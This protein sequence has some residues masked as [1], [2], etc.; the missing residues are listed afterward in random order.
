MVRPRQHKTKFSRFSELSVEVQIIILDY[1]LN[2]ICRTDRPPTNGPRRKKDLPK[3]LAPF[4]CVSRI[5]QDYFESKTFHN[6][7]LGPADIP[8]FCSMTLSERRRRFVKHV[9][10]I[11][12]LKC[13]FNLNT[14]KMN[15]LDRGMNNL[16]FTMAIKKLL[17][18][19]STWKVTDNQNISLEIGL[20]VPHKTKDW[21]ADKRREEIYSE[22]LGVISPWFV[23]YPEFFWHGHRDHWNGYFSFYGTP[24]NS[25]D[26]SKGITEKLLWNHPLRLIPDRITEKLLGN[27]P[28][29]LI[30]DSSLKRGD[31]V[32]RLPIAEAITKFLIRLEYFPNF[33]PETLEYIFR[34][35]PRLQEIRVERWRFG[36][37]NYDEVWDTQRK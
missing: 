8:E 4:A 25:R 1:F 21:D 6:L 9:L 10:L 18:V 3:S 35:L 31:G 16:E 20:H 5:W 27:H 28:L 2:R 24:S 19:F 33:S 14:D 11:Y 29:R 30:P 23:R 36:S 22:Y 13:D 7:R 15:N 17:Q 32:F 12:S 34:S 37:A 26:K